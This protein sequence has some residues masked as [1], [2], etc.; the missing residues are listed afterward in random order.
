MGRKAPH[1]PEPKTAHAIAAPSALHRPAHPRDRQRLRAQRLGQGGRHV[2]RT[3]LLGFYVR[4][5]LGLHGVAVAWQTQ[6]AR[7]PLGGPARS[8]G[9]RRL[10]IFKRLAAIERARRGHGLHRITG[11]QPVGGPHA[12]SQCSPTT[13]AGGGRSGRAIVK[14]TLR[15]EDHAA[16]REDRAALRL[17]R[18]R[19]PAAFSRHLCE[20]STPMRCATTDVPAQDGAASRAIFRRPQRPSSP[21]RAARRAEGTSRHRSPSPQRRSCTRRRRLSRQRRSR[22]GLRKIRALRVACS[23]ARAAT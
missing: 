14:R 13:S 12:V 1:K 16:A 2:A 3:W 6:I 20:G 4:G 22:R 19:P 18:A 21:P 17:R 9:A 10:V 8:G 15:P 11:L 23:R 7:A 5:N